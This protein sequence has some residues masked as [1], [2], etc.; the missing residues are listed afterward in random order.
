MIRRVL[1]NL[2]TGRYG[3]DKLN[4]TLVGAGLVINILIS[5]FRIL[6]AGLIYSSSSFYIA[7]RII[8]F[9]PYIPYLTAFFRAF[10][11]NFEKRRNEERAFM[12]L[13]GRWIKYFS[14]KLIQSRDR[15]HRYFNCPSCHR[16]LRVPR[17]RGKIKIDCPHCRRQFTKRT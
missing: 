1:R 17:N 14:Q 9:I 15:N 2:F 5:L 11:K 13:A 6:F 12:K 16:T 8:S 4:F 7:F 10:S 3:F